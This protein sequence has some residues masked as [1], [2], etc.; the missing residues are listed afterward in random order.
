MSAFTIII[1]L[2][3]IITIII[4]LGKYTNSLD[5][6]LPTK[7]LDLLKTTPTTEGFVE[8]VNK[9]PQ[10]AF[11]E[12]V[13]YIINLVTK[14][15]NQK[16]FFYNPESLYQSYT[17]TWNGDPV[18]SIEPLKNAIR[19]SVKENSALSEQ[20]EIYVI[21]Y[22]DQYVNYESDRKELAPGAIEGNYSGGNIGKHYTGNSL[23]TKMALSKN[24]KIMDQIQ[25]NQSQ[26]VGKSGIS[27]TQLLARM[28]KEQLPS[29][30]RRI[31]DPDIRG[32]SK[33]M[34][35]QLARVGTLKDPNSLV[36]SALFTTKDLLV[37]GRGV[38]DTSEYDSLCQ[39]YLDKTKDSE[40]AMLKKITSRYYNIGKSYERLKSDS[41]ENLFKRSIGK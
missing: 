2:I 3:V 24:N 17:A 9:T 10:V 19:E 40:D 4:V 20:I 8:L 13:E 27:P 39:S 16:M 36:D 5:A 18:S 12:S 11:N 29:Y 33:P 22:V 1:I 7:V 31:T 28:P 21:P 23:G 15:M 30:N 38:G 26:L 37:S 41:L 35:E 14:Y 6:I 32:Y 25:K 34:M